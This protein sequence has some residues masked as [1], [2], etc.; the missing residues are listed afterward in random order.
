V[1]Q[2]SP[3]STRRPP[4]CMYTSGG[5]INIIPRS[6][7]SSLS[8]SFRLEWYNVVTARVHNSC[9]RG[10]SVLNYY[11][12][13]DE[14]ETHLSH[15]GQLFN[16]YLM[17]LRKIPA[18]VS[19]N[20]SRRTERVPYIHVQSC[21]FAPRCHMVRRLGNCELSVCSDGSRALCGALVEVCLSSCRRPT[22]CMSDIRRSQWCGPTRGRML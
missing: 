22:K 3:R 4:A 2:Y 1:P 5:L 9:D 8:P 12:S 18:N 17:P 21:T 11:H 20:L 13:W 7:S 19:G 10:I 6:H 14:F 15:S 16:I